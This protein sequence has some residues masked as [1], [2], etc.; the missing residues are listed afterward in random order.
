MKTIF[1]AFAAFS[2]LLMFTAAATPAFAA[3]APA[4][5]LVPVAAAPAD[6][7]I[8]RDM[9]WKCGPNGCTAAQANSRP[10]IVCAQAARK[11]GKLTSFAVSGVEFDAA[12]LEACNA[13]A[14]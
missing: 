5:R 7:V 3:P 9:L 13:K 6:Q 11:V 2:T 12:A 14:K 1:A 4:Y 10:A 8:V